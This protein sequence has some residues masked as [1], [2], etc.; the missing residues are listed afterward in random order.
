MQE[1]AAEAAKPPAPV[2][3]KRVG[4][5]RELRHSGGVG[6]SLHE[7]RREA[8]QPHEDRILAWL[9]AGHTFIASPG[10]VRDVLSEAEDAPI[11][12]TPTIL[13]DGV[14]AWPQD[15]LYYLR[16][17][18]VKL[19]GAFLEHL[20]GQDFAPPEVVDVTGLEF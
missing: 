15:L 9:E 14:W 3:L 18:H 16:T 12:G 2:K 7:S 6:P 11:S 17:Y 1:A 4:F 8:A 19:P 13:T 5:F 10:V 20:L